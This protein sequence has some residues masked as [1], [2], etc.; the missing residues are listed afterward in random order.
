MLTYNTMRFGTDTFS[1]ATKQAMIIAKNPLNANR[2]FTHIKGFTV[3]G[4]NLTADNVRFFFRVVDTDGIYSHGRYNDDVYFFYFSASGKLM[5]SHVAG[6]SV[7]QTIDLDDI[8]TDYEKANLDNLLAVA[9]DDTFAGL[10]IFPIIALKGDDSPTVKLTAQFDK[11]V[12]TLDQVFENQHAFDTP[13]KVVDVVSEPETVGN[14]SVD[15]T[16]AYKV[17]A[18]DSFSTFGKLSD[19]IGKTVAA[20]N[21]RTVQHVDAVDDVNAAKIGKFVVYYSDGDCPVFGDSADLF[22]VVKNYYLPL[23]YCAVIVKHSN[24]NG[25]QIKAFAKFD[26]T[27]YSTTKKALGTGSGSSQTFTLPTS[28][29]LDPTDLKVY[30][31]DVLT[32]DYVLDV[33]ANTITLTAASGA[34]ITATYTYNLQ[35]ENW[36]EL[37]ADPTQHD[38]SDGLFVTRYHCTNVKQFGDNILVSAIRLQFIRGSNG[39]V[40]YVH[41]FTAGW[42]V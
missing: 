22:S 16:V 6:F 9:D 41:S 37:T 33:T 10:D 21:Y 36:I 35:D 18:S 5:T 7:F 30:V 42:S 19:L 39:S 28:K 17:N 20:I 15:I 31:N 14:A 25:A 1:F 27:K 13:V 34:A 2:N 23:K 38:F 11:R 12:E 40:P 26:P 8:F 3:A 32:S 4:E 24:L 29:F